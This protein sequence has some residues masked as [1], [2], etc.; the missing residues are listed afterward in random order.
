MLPDTPRPRLAQGFDAAPSKALSLRLRHVGI[1]LI[2]W[3]WPPTLDSNGGSHQDSRSGC[4]GGR[5]LLPAV[6]GPA[7]IALR[8]RSSF[9]SIG[10]RGQ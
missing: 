10:D 5:V 3:N 4:G 6:G 9:M 8:V 1:V 7:W 2:E